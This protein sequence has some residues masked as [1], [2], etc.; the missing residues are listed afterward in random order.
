[1]VLLMAKLSAGL[2]IPRAGKFILGPMVT[3]YWGY[4][5]I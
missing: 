2:T 1:M 5:A 3:E 4:N